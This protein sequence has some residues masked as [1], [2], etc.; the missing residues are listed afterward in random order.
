MHPDKLY[1]HLLTNPDISNELL[2]SAFGH[3]DPIGRLDIEND[4]S[5]TGSE[6]I[7][8]LVNIFKN[9]DQDGK[10]MQISEEDRHEINN[11]FS[12]LKIAHQE[13]STAPTTTDSLGLNEPTP[14]LEIPNSIRE[15]YQISNTNRKKNKQKKK[16]K[17]LEASNDPSLS[18]C[19]IIKSQYMKD[20]KE[21]KM[22]DFKDI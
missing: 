2:E 20:N 6:Q 5:I 10:G 19:N 12:D 22:Q 14:F 16:A 18:V 9:S 15:I 21:N 7:L 13:S 11:C 17:D 4:V 8:K 1:A 3:S